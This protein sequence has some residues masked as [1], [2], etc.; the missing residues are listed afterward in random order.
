MGSKPSV[1]IIETHVSEMKT[2]K[3]FILSIS[4]ALVFFVKSGQTSNCIAS[5]GPGKGLPCVFPFKYNDVVYYTCSNANKHVTN[6]KPWCSTLVDREGNHIGGVG[7]WGNCDET[8]PLLLNDFNSRDTCECLPPSQCRWSADAMLKALLL[9]RNHPKIKEQ[10]RKI[11]KHI[12]DPKKRLVFCCGPDQ[13]PPV[14][15]NITSLPEYDYAYDEIKPCATLARDGYSCVPSNQCDNLLD[16]RGFT[17]PI[18]E[19]PSQKCCH[20]SKKILENEMEN[21]DKIKPCSAFK[22]EGYQCVPRDNCRGLADIRTDD[23]DI[24]SD[25]PYY[26]DESAAPPCEDSSQICCHDDKLKRK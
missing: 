8:C 25:D 23:F 12:C 16:V 14:Y 19:D 17:E 10:S 1:E 11:R 2:Y 24:L 15:L 22:N 3:I 13:K 5:S 4:F 21:K 9:P 26:D 7:A 18:C 6:N 20:V